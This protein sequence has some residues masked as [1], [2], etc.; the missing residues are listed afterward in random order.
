MSAEDF[1]PVEFLHVAV[2]RSRDKAK[3]CGAPKGVQ[4]NL[5]ILWRRLK[6]I[7]A[8]ENEC[9]PRRI[10]MFGPPN[11]GKSTLLNELLG[12]DILTTSP[13]PMTRTVI[14]AH[15]VDAASS[16]SAWNV[17]VVH[18]DEFIQSFEY[19]T[20][21]EVATTVQQYGSHRNS[22][23]EVKQIIVKS[24]FG[25]SRLMERNGVLIDTPGAELAFEQTDQVRRDDTCRAIE[26]LKDVHVVLFCV[27][28]D[29]IGSASEKAFYQNHMRLLDPINIVNFKDTSSDPDSLVHETV[30]NYGFKQDRIYLVSSRDAQ[31]AKNETEKDASG[32]PKL[33]QAILQELDKLTPQ[34]GLISCMSEFGSVLNNQGDNARN[35]LPESVHLTRF[36]QCANKVGSPTWR[37]PIACFQ[38]IIK[39]LQKG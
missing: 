29:Q 24:A 16:D 23:P 10:G 28:A 21:A 14:E 31:R 2:Q 8:F 4:D 15:R 20:P 30:R 22:G 35:L 12:E 17:E 11:R 36:I 1:K 32:V 37:E 5:E 26:M 33:E 6:Q 9:S 27:R 38:K 19:S 3:E 34:Q 18:D 25:N 13:I 7:R 39:K